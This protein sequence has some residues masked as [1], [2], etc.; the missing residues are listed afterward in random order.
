MTF[1][2]VATSSVLVVLLTFVWAREFRLRRALQS[3]LAR[4]F[5]QWRNTHEATEPAPKNH[6]AHDRAYSGNDRRM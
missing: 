2:L 6:D 5:T 3:L 1:A 4:I